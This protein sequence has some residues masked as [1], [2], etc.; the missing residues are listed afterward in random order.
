MSGLLHTLSTAPADRA[1][2]VR[3]GRAITA[4]QIRATAADIAARMSGDR[5]Y[6]Y[7]VSAAL[8]AAGL[9]AAASKRATVCCPAHLQPAYLREIGAEDAVLLTDQSVAL[10]QDEDAAI[11]APDMLDFV[12]YTSGVTGAPKPVHKA[13]AQLDAEARV[14]ED[15]WGSRAGRAVAT[16]SHQHIYGMLFRLFW[17][18][19][20]GRL[21]EDR[22]AEYWESVV[23]GPGTMLI[24]SPAHL[25]RLPSTLAGAGPGLIFSSGAALPF[26]A[27]Q[28]ARDLFGVLPIEVLGSTE[29]GGI[30][31]R[32]QD[33]AG[34][35]WTPLPSVRVNIN[36][37]SLLEVTSPFAGS[38]SHVTGDAAEFVGDRFRLLGRADRVAKIDGKRVSLARVEDALLALPFVEAAAAIDLPDRKGALGAIVELS[39]DGKSAL[40]EKGAFRLSRAFRSGLAERLEPAERPKHWRFASIPLNAQGKRVQAQLRACFAEPTGTVVARDDENAQVAMTLTPDLIWF[41]GHFP[42]QPVLPGIAQ[43]HMAVQWAER[44]WDWKPAGANLS[45]LKFRRILRAGDVVTLSLARDLKRQRLAFAYRLKDVL[46]SDGTIGGAP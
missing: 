30:A 18:V 36:A 32:Q 40:L 17:P 3:D 15:V 45:Q 13:I 27:A 25:T 20:G 39:A 41:R 7:T 1:L 42:D 28:G 11:D 26:A 12:F 16:V 34:A 9:L 19:L 14:L 5:V 29:T 21:S 8:F 44:L 37:D 6:L 33:D 46:A 35:S 23:A 38:G 24:T 2:F 4:G 22:A 10:S 31:W 43:V